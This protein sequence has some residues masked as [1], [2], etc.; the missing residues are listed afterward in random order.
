MISQYF[1]PFCVE[2]DS[3][4]QKKTPVSQ[5]SLLDLIDQRL[6]VFRLDP[7]HFSPQPI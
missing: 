1:M 7:L 4:K 2:N 3:F 5:R 6:P